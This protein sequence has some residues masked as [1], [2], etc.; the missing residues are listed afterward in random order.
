MLDLIE[1]YEK[2]GFQL[3]NRISELNGI[4]RDKSL[5]TIE[6]EKLTARR[7]MLS[8]ERSEIVADLIEMKQHLRKE[9]MPY[10]RP[11]T[12]SRLCS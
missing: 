6:R 1:S 5:Q 9:E 10:V 3:Q 11:E 12:C 4:L 8:R 2:T 7:D